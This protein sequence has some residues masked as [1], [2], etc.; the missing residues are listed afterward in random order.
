MTTPSLSEVSSTQKR[1]GPFGPAIA[2]LPENQK[3]ETALVTDPAANVL[4][5]LAESGFSQL[6][7]VDIHGRVH[8]VFS[9]ESFGRRM[10]E[11]HSL[12]IDLNTL[13]VRETDLEKPRFISPDTFIDTGADWKEVD[14]VLVGDAD[15][16]LGI[17]TLTD[18]YGRLND[19]AEAF[20]L[21]YE[22]EH[23]IRDMFR[24]L[25]SPTDLAE[26]MT[27]LSD[28]SDDPEIKASAALQQ[29]LDAR[30]SSLSDPEITKTINFA[31]GQM[32]RAARQRARSRAV[33]E[34]EDFTFAQ[35]GHVIF[36]ADHW[37]R[38]DPV[39]KQS[40]EILQLDFA[41]INDLRNTVF[42]FRRSIGPRDTDRLR[43]F[44]DKLRYDRSLRQ[45]DES[46]EMNDNSERARLDK[47][48]RAVHPR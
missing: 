2:L 25:Y 26:L 29:L 32:N 38:F 39:F 42:H 16:L 12:S 5:R 47:V 45:Q 18:I 10:S 21:L 19:F 27:D 48:N 43:R 11:I 35:Y 1:P 6:P 36:D 15:N 9:W 20:V 23:E 24:D 14:Y 13:P 31:I 40:R 44:R 33:R 22:I 7:V 8:G 17:L 37:P 28:A 41:R 34:L 46:S 3:I 30:P 4:E